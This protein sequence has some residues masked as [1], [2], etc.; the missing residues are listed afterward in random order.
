M[1]K[2]IHFQFRL[3]VSGDGPNSA[4]AIANLNALCR[5]HLM[6]RH[7]IEIVDV[8]REPKRA[9]ADEVVLTPMLMKLSPGPI[10]KI[11]GNLSQLHNVMLMLGLPA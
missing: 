9:L 7:E 11:I 6:D 3:Y 5:E 8:F 2:P 4:L 1:S 10:R